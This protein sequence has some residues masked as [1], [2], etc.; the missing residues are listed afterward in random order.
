MAIL[1]RTNRLRSCFLALLGA[2]LLGSCSGDEPTGPQDPVA[3]IPSSVSVAPATVALSA[4]GDTVRLTAQVRD[5]NGELMGE[6]AVTWSSGAPATATVDAMGLVTAVSNGNATITAQAG[7]VAASAAVAV[8]QAPAALTLAPDSLTFEAVG[9]TATIVATVSDANGRA[10]ESAQVAWASADTTV[11]TVDAAGLVTAVSNGNAT[12]TAQAGSVAASAAV[13]VHQAPAALTLVPDSLTFEA[14]GDTATIVATVSDANGHEVAGAI[15]AW[16]SDDPSVATV[17]STGLVTAI[18]PGSTTVTATSGMLTA[19]TDVEVWDISSDREVLEYLYHATGGDGWRDNT[20]W[21]TDAPISEWAGVTTYENGRVRYLR[22]RDNNLKG[23]I[24][25]SLGRLDQLV[26]LQLSGN[27]L[28]GRIPPEIGELRQLRDLFLSRNELS[29]SLPPE[30]GDMADLR[31]LSVSRNNLSGPIPQ[32]F[33][34]LNLTRLYFGRTHLCLPPGLKAWYDSIEQS[35]DDPLPCIPVTADREALVALYKATD[36][37]AWDE[38]ENWLSE[39]LINTWHGVT[40][41]EDGHVI[42]LVLSGNNLSGPLPREIGDLVHLERLALFNNALSGPIPPEIGNLAKVRD[43]SL[44][45][46]EFEG[47]IPPE[48][49]G[50]VSADTIFLSRNHLSGPIPSEIGNLESLE[51]LALFENQLTGPL[52]PSLG[53][54][55]NLVN[56]ELVDNRIDGPL[57]GEIGDMTSLEEFSIYRNEVSGSLPLE[58]V[59]LKALKEFS[60]DDNRMVGPIPPELAD[61][62]S[63]EELSLSRNG[64][65]G[66]IPRELGNLSN[67]RQLWLFDNE[68]TGEIPL[69]LGNLAKLEDLRIGNNP[70]TGRIPSELGKLVALELLNLGSSNLS[71]PIPPELGQLSS[72]A[73][74]GLCRNNLSGPIPPELGDIQTLERLDLCHNPELGGLMPRSLMKLESLSQ[75]LFYQTEICPQIDGEFQ[76]WLVEVQAQGAECDPAEVERLALGEFFAKTGGQAWTNRAGWNSG[77]ALD[78][79]HG[80]TIADGRV[81]ELALPANGLRGPLASEIANLTEL[82]VL[83]VGD[84]RLAG[85]FPVVITSMS[86]LDTIR[87]SDNREM[88]GRLP[89]QLIELEG[90]QTLA[91]ANTGLCASPSETFQRWLGGLRLANG[92]TCGNPEQATLS[93]P[94]VYLT[95]AIQRPEGDVPLI[96]GRDALLRVFLESEEPQAYFEPEVVATLSRGGQEIHRVVMRRDSDLLAT[97][98]DEGDLRNSYNAL[99]PSRYILPGTE[100]VVEA[101]PGGLVPLVPG[102]QT[103][104]P[105]SGAEPLNVIQVPPME[106]TVVPVVEAVQPDSS[107]YEWTDNIADD[108]PEVGLLRNAFPISDFSAR[109]RE[110]YVTSLDLTSRSDR[111]RLILELEAVR[112][113][114]N[115]RGYWYAAAASKDDTVRGL[116]RLGGRVSIGKPLNTEMAHEL[117]HNLNLEHAPCGG[118]SD[119]DPEF[120]Y[121]NGSIG[122]W[123]YDFRDGTVV[124]PARGRD[125]MGYCYEQGWLSD[126]YF[127]KV[128]NYR[129]EVEARSARMMASATPRS[130]TLILWGGVVNGELRIEP[131]FPMTTTAR[132][133]EEAGLY[134]LEGIGTDGQVRLSLAFTPGE[135]KFGDKYFFFTV[136]IE[137]DWA[138]SLDRLTLTGPEGT[139]TVNA[140][141]EQALSIVTD[142]ATGRIQSILRDWDDVLPA[143]IG[144]ADSYAV[145][146]FR[147]LGEAVTLQR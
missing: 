41:N 67:L 38:N 50:L 45:G 145:T 89:F 68:L 23:P 21:L 51:R 66:P 111:W 34:G 1:R 83:N 46:N 109:T 79:W 92:A 19:S 35:D 93:M 142:P 37:P 98:A 127:E 87:V 55:K 15:P 114:E 85:E 116:A 77:A 123:G 47:P 27:A 76:E 112:A 57:P 14:M 10:I 53:N 125:I 107:I 136:P 71:G 104:F 94:V 99:I 36:G 13:A 90:L 73:S 117:G 42:Q 63:L 5:Q 135:D 105:A 122:A 84:N 118:A 52:P 102:S 78:T 18:R 80:V 120:P 60:A 124:S 108:S 31:H 134:R 61:L 110:T 141:D 144:L 86:E 43:L 119:P 22:L 12:I 8:H 95:Q 139:V 11:V 143:T 128:I 70:L 33:A 82:R 96:Q 29:G 133:P 97:S 100:L 129:A 17:A 126:Y 131:P 40:T 2:W 138:E 58:L 7:S 130:E 115:G 74:L 64:F 39:Q 91:F 32:T 59:K 20:N 4:L 103:R 140:T 44:S 24:P 106:L 26:I 9:D 147:G 49:G 137:A 65:S 54:L 16:T 132:L 88:E 30:I 101:D 48:I 69:E 75:F 28:S 146:T 121:A 25:R 81:R 72:L 3:P 56:L 113:A 62:I 6:V